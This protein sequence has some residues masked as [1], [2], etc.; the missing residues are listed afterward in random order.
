M[1]WPGSSLRRS[2]GAAASKMCSILGAALAFLHQDWL[3]SP[4]SRGA[5][6]PGMTCARARA[7]E[8]R[9]EW[10]TGRN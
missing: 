6:S 7:R 8:G 3:L 9:E 2:R 10:E 4:R 1:L 5:E